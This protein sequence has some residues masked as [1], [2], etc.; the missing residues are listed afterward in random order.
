MVWVVGR[1]TLRPLHPRHRNPATGVEFN[2]RPRPQER[3]SG[4]VGCLSST[5][6]SSK[7]GVGSIRR[8][9]LRRNKEG[10]LLVILSIFVKVE[11]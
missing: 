1:G 10:S 6:G 7:K 4:R 3:V 8:R 5:E 11:S 2:R 9:I